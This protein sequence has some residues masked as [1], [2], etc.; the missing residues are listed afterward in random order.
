MITSILIFLGGFIVG[1]LVARNNIKKVNKIVAE[2]KETAAELD[3]KIEKL[4][5]KYKKLLGKD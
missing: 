4:P 1:V 5:A 3:E 2:A